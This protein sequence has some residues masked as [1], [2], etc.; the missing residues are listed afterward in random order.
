MTILG[1][2]TVAYLEI[3]SCAFVEIDE[4][5]DQAVVRHEWSRKGART[6]VG[7]YRITDFLTAG[8]Q[9]A[10]RAGQSFASDDVRGDSRL[11]PAQFSALGIA[12]IVCVPIIA[13]D[14]WRFA[15]VIHDS[16]PRKW[17]ED[18]VELIREVTART[19]ARL[20]RARVEEQVRRG[21]E[22]LD[23]L[24][25]QSPTGFYIVDAEFRI[26]HM[27]AD[28]Q[29]RAFRN[30]NPAIGRRFDEAIRILWPEPL[31]TEI[32]GIFRHTL[33]T[34]EPYQSP[35]LVS[36]RADMHEVETYDWQLQRI[37]MPDGRHA[38]VCY[39]YDT[40]QLRRAE[41]QLL[42]ADRRKDE[43]LATL[44][45]EL[46]NPLAPIRNGLHYLRRLRGSTD[47]KVAELHEMMERQVTHMVRMVDDL[48][49]VSRITRG[50]VRMRKEQV[51]LAT[52]LHGAIETSRPLIEAGGHTLSVAMC[53][54]PLILDA[55]VVRLTQVFANLLNN[56][57]KYTDTGGQISITTR[58]EGSISLVSI[59]DSGIGIPS[60][61]LAKVFDLFTQADRAHGRAQGGLGIGLTLARSMVDMHGGTI[62]ARSGGPGLGS[63][64]L[65][66]LP[67]A[68]T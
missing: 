52:I 7:T 36:E 3:A 19:W 2:K 60:D 25:Y 12:S 23:V 21:A 9:K 49:E 38:V 18:Q 17:R 68:T 62:E 24:I 8:I 15:V 13:N 61:M 35:G 4:S 54:E 45:H 64:F 40:T 39:Y 41:Q 34:G 28:S 56:A 11:M 29:A 30:V 5:T 59:R 48:M 31:A 16:E 42:E 32:I 63:E 47:H 14:R 22:L 6:I 65:V 51:D 55:D 33:E 27:N 10:L 26:S 67:L 37:T 58:R 1:A 57:A 20:E 50:N 53:D 43:F 46:R 44:A 66:R